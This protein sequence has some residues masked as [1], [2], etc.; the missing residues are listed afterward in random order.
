MGETVLYSYGLAGVKRTA[1]TQQH[2]ADARLG[3]GY[4]MSRWSAKGVN[5][6]QVD[7]QTYPVSAGTINV[8]S[9]IEYD[10]DA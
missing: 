2:F 9:S 5:L 3:S 8:S 10:R 4:L 7:L 1:L 6:W